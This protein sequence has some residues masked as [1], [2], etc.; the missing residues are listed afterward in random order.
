MN[1]PHAEV[2]DSNQHIDYFENEEGHNEDHSPPQQYWPIEHSSRLDRLNRRL[3]GLDPEEAEGEEEP[4]GPEG[5]NRFIGVE[6][7]ERGG[8]LLLDANNLSGGGG[9]AGRAGRAPLSHC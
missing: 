9:A 1:F 2:P 6:Q 4:I 3:I 8:A 5:N 7:F